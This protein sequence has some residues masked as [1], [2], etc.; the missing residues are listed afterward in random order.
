[1]RTTLTAIILAAMI[2]SLAGAAKPKTKSLEDFLPVTLA[3]A[4]RQKEPPPPLGMPPASGPRDAHGAYLLPDPRFVNVNLMW[5]KDLAFEKAQFK[6]A[7]AGETDEN[8]TLG[9]KLEGFDV[10]GV[11]VERTQYLPTADGRRGDKSEAR[12]LLGDRIV[13]L[14][15]VERPTDANEPLDFIRKLDLRGLTT[16]AT[17]AA[18]KKG[19]K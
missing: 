15:S 11:F 19:A 6:V 3:G 18:P 2:P 4:K 17:P 13:V 14:V 12:A 8:L 5:V 9:L 10:D 1:M 7:K 16:L